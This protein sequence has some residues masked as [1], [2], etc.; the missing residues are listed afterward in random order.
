MKRNALIITIITAVAGVL[1]VTQYSGLFQESPPVPIEW[2]A[3]PQKIEIDRTSFLLPQSEYDAET[4][5][6]CKKLLLA[7][8]EIKRKSNIELVNAV[9]SKDKKSVVYAFRDR[10]I[11]GA[12]YFFQVD[13]ETKQFLQKFWMP[14][15]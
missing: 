9:R 5:S 1:L 8:R 10:S 4:I 11:C 2:T 7:A 3:H 13:I 12:T 6:R 15:A 14:D